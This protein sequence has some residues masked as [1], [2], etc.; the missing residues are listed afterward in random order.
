MELLRSK[1]IWWNHYLIVDRTSLAELVELSGGV[2]SGDRK[3]SGVEIVESMPNASETP[4]AALMAQA[5]I[6]RSLCNSSPVWTKNADP[7]VLWGL[8]TQRMRS[9]LAVEKFNSVDALFKFSNGEAVCQF[10][11]L[12]VLSYWSGR[13]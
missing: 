13:D 4:D 1:N 6:A 12:Q 2:F 8:M 9:D 11:T 3:M 5:Q 7:E 10:P